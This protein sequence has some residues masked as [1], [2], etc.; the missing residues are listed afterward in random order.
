MFPKLNKQAFN[1]LAQYNNLEKSDYVVE[2]MNGES[3]EWWT[4]DTWSES[5]TDAA[6]YNENKAK[7][8]AE[9][10]G[11]SPTWFEV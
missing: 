3:R 6:W 1:R 7:E 5:E 11:G 8:V 10:V 9:E 2:R 4:G